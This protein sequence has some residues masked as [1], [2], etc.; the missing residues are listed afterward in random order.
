MDPFA[1]SGTTMVAVVDAV[2]EANLSS[3]YILGYECN[4]FLHLVARSKFEALRAPS[5]TFLAVAKRVAAAALRNRV[6]PAPTPQ[7]ATFANPSYFAP[8]DLDQ[9]LKLRR[10]IDLAEEEGASPLDVDLARVCLAATIE[11]VSGL[12]RD[13]RALRHVPDK[14]RAS[15]GAEFLRRAEQIDDD[16]ARPPARVR[17]RVEWGDGRTLRPKPPQRGSLDVVIFSPPYPNNID[18]TEVYKLEAWLLGLIQSQADF[19][20]QRL[21]TLYSHP[22]ILRTRDGCESSAPDET[23]VDRLVAPLLAVVPNDRYNRARVEMIRG[24]ARDLLQTLQACYRAVRP[25]GHLVYIVG[26]ST[27]G[28]GADAFVIAADLLIAKLAQHIGFD[29]TSVDVA[30]ALRRRQTTSDFLRESVVFARKP[31]VV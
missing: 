21:R 17:G 27:H 19:L 16:L 2:V 18:Y 14:Q 1:G 12:R 26:N 13:G 8:A 25:G 31:E 10:A 24:Y 29:V 20:D 30:R 9:L 22:S 15:P 7:L 3:A 5:R 23:T 11:P 4:P 6:S 28:H